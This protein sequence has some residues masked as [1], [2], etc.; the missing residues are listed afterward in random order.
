M[1]RRQGAISGLDCWRGWPA[2]PAPNQPKRK[3]GGDSGVGISIAERE[4]KEDGEG[5]C[6]HAGPGCQT[7]RGRAQRLEWAVQAAAEQADR[8]VKTARRCLFTRGRSGR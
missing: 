8:A 4:R 3:A 5:R 6:C 7:E 1:R 2:K